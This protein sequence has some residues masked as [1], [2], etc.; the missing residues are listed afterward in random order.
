MIF[1][2][3]V[4]IRPG[5]KKDSDNFV[6]WLK[7][8]KRK[9]QPIYILGDLFDYWVTG[10][11]QCFAEVLEALKDPQVSVLPGNRDFLLANSFKDVVR[12]LEEEV[13]ITAPRSRKVLLAHGH[14][15][16][17]GDYGF[18]VLHALGWPVL[19]YIDR[20]LPALLKERLARFMIA[21][22]SAVR[23]PRASIEPDIAR[24]R[25]VDTVMCGHLH[26]MILTDTLIVLPSFHDSGQWLVWD[27]QSPRVQPA[28]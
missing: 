5:I 27:E 14:T 19:R 23:T 21:S 12:V 17:R 20:H 1:I 9:H 18:K 2:A 25:G 8:S 7:E 11:E 13:V 26:R 10:M 28:G 3:D 4:H 22:S 6:Y 16:T 15:L 24:R